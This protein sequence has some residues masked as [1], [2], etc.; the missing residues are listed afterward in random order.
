MAVSPCSYD[1]F[2][3][4]YSAEICRARRKLENIHLILVH[5]T[6]QQ[7]RDDKIRSVEQN[8]T[9]FNNVIIPGI[10]LL[11][12]C[13]SFMWVNRTEASFTG[14]SQNNV[15]P[16]GYTSKNPTSDYIAH[17]LVASQIR[18][19][20]ISF[21]SAPDYAVQLAENLISLK[22]GSKNFV[23][24]TVREI[25]RDNKNK[26]RTI[27]FDLWQET[28]NYMESIGLTTLVIRDTAKASET[29]LFQNSIEVPEASIHLPL[30]LAIYEKAHL[31]F[32]KNN[33]PGTLQLYSKANTIFFN[34]FDDDEVAL[35]RN[36]YETNFGMHEGD[37]YP[38][39]TKSK[40][41]VW[42]Q[43]NRE[44]IIELIS[45]SFSQSSEKGELN[46]FRNLENIRSSIVVAFRNLVKETKYGILDEDV[47]LLKAIKNLN[48]QHKIFQ[49]F[50]EQIRQMSDVHIE[51]SIADELI[52][53]TSSKKVDSFTLDELRE[54]S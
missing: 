29:Q 13:S 30:R 40:Q 41:F 8:Q 42:N 19:D 3:F 46:D 54:R 25:E 35:S 9:F 12:S 44:N 7:F 24:L 15:F 47:E 2:T 6:K 22:C 11:P 34:S 43:E 45:N 17:S 5:G 51:K 23:T 49:N 16:R 28:I 27:N 38:F 1:F 39:S 48:E 14:L 33:G 4:L 18:K 52:Q 36:W 32:T 10:S 53:R 50:D 21:L 20:E 31:N 37:Q 26:T